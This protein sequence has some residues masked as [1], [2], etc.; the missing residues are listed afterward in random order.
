MLLPL[1]SVLIP[2]DGNM[3]MMVVG[4]RTYLPDIGQIMDYTLVPWPQGD[5]GDEDGNPDI[6][7]LMHDQVGELI[8]EGYSDEED[9]EHVLFLEGL[10]KDDYVVAV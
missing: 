8:H 6:Y 3:R 7:Y 5:V 9:V 4:R 2:Q 10:N 1:G